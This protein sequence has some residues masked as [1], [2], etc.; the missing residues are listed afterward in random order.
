MLVYLVS[1]AHRASVNLD[2]ILETAGWASECCFAK[3]YNKPIVKVSNYAN[4]V[5]SGK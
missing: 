4:S 5:V 3:Y 2:D 1:A